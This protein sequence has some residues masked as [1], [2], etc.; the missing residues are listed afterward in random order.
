MTQS[1]AGSGGAVRN[2][3]FARLLV[4][5]RKSEPPEQVQYRRDL[6]RGLSGRVVDLGAGDGANFPH[7]PTSVTEVI[8]V[9]PEP[10]L[11]ERALVNA[12]SAPVP[13]TVVDSLAERLPLGDVS[14]DA[15]G[16]GAG[17]VHGS[18]SA[19]GAGR[20]L[21]GY[22]S[23]WRAALLRARH[24]LRPKAGARPTRRPADGLLAVCRRW[25]PPGPR[26]RRSDHVSWLSD[27]SVPTPVCEAVRTGDPGCPAHPGHCA[28]RALTASGGL[29]RCF[30]WS[31]APWR[32]RSWRLR[33]AD[34]T[35]RRRSVRL[36]GKFE[37]SPPGAASPC[38]QPGASGTRRYHAHS[39][40]SSMVRSTCTSPG[41]CAGSPRSNL[42]SGVQTGH[43]SRSSCSCPSS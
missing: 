1:P 16:R 15:A 40:V 32:S 33:S 29:G 18:R 36:N 3:L 6:L 31:P 10:Y 19:G 12:G 14:V 38:T 17:A 22:P 9:E 5:L 21:A 7:F 4:R 43:A 42:K 25:L 37:R 23:G 24:R 2:P 41:E 20:A 8:A 11:R 39:S 30:C 26:H 28:A 13:V 34:R 27:R 35:R